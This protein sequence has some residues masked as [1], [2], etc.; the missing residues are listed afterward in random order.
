MFMIT[1]TRSLPWTTSTTTTKGNP[2]KR[3]TSKISCQINSSSLVRSFRLALRC[4]LTRG[5][6]VWNSIVCFESYCGVLYIHKGVRLCINKYQCGMG[7]ASQLCDPG[8][9][10]GV[11]AVAVELRITVAHCEH[12]NL[13]CGWTRVDEWP[14]SWEIKKCR[15]KWMS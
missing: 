3:G 13:G 15:L 10:Q 11:N 12:T 8:T 7:W 4:E 6:F 1:S 9:L 5:V 14:R 2:I